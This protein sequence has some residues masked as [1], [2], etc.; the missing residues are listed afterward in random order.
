MDPRFGYKLPHIH[1]SLPTLGFN[2]R[3]TAVFLFRVC[4]ITSRATSLALF[5]T[6]TRPYGMFLAIALDAVI[7][8][9]V[10]VSY[11]FQVGKFAPVGRMAF[12]RAGAKRPRNKAAFGAL[13]GPFWPVFEVRTSFTSS[14]RCSSAVWRPSWRRTR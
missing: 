11:Q 7:M 9:V 1:S 6:V 5:Q 14:R 8:T 10:T 3:F 2:G 4:E 12:V 13:S